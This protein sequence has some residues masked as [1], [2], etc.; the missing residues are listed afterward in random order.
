MDLAAVCSRNFSR[1]IQSQPK[2]CLTASYLV[3]ADCR[4]K[5]RHELSITQHLTAVGNRQNNALGFARGM[6]DYVCAVPV[7]YSVPK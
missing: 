7:L 4:A 2:A 3:A 1:D 6:E 5:D